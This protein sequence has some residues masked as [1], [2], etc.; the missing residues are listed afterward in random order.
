MKQHDISPPN[1]SSYRMGDVIRYKCP[2]RSGLLCYK[3]LKEGNSNKYLVINNTEYVRTTGIRS[4]DIFIFLEK[5]PHL[6]SYVQVIHN[7]QI[8]VFA[9]ATLH[10]SNFELIS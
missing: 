1:M 7:N 2:R 4:N 8:V 5:I 6:H 10:D 9:F 3:K